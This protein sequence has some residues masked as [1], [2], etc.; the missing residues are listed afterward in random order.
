MLDRIIATKRAQLDL[1]STR[2]ELERLKA[3]AFERP[4]VRSLKTALSLANRL[5]VIAEIKKRSPS[6]GP[7]NQGLDVVRFAREYEANGA[8]A[9]SVLTETD[10][11]DGSLN[12]LKA[13]RSVVKLPVLRKDFV[14]SEYQVWESRA[15]GADALLLIVA[16]LNKER[17]GQLIELCCV[18]SLEPLVEVHTEAELKSVLEF[19]PELIAVN[20]RDLRTFEVDNNTIARLAPLI[21][22]NTVIVSAS[23]VQTRDDMIS[24]EKLGINAVLIGETLVTAP[25]PGRRLRELRG[26]S[27]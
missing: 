9:I 26:E 17:L 3:L 12:D 20:N 16:C 25:D 8:N 7:L 19:K 14:I 13:A 10:F 5:A 15:A 22:A 27:A 6:R 18:A 2:T 21:P 11:F 4:P 23:G 1:V 24:L